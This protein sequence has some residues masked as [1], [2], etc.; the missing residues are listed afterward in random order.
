MPLGI[1]VAMFFVM[2]TVSFKSYRTY[3]QGR[4][5]P[6]MRI[7]ATAEDILR[8]AQAY[9]HAKQNEAGYGKFLANRRPFG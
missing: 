5:G 3:E 8:A 6:I 9:L 4:S 7:D 1:G 2:A